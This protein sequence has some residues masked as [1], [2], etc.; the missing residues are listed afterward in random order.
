MYQQVKGMRGVGEYFQG[1]NGLGAFY[2]PEY[3]R[4]INGLGSSM[5][6]G[7]GTGCGCAGV[8]DAAAAATTPSPSTVN[9]STKGALMI[10]G[11]AVVLIALAVVP[12][13][14]DG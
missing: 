14:W 8:G 3:E 4:P 6:R 10:A 13:I 2:A 5:R 11:A 9:S 1:T 7:M 12:N